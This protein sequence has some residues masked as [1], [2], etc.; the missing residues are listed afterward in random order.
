MKIDEMIET[1][2]FLLYLYNKYAHKI[3]K[4]ISH[5]DLKLLLII[6]YNDKDLKEIIKE[7]KE[8]KKQFLN[9]IKEGDLQKAYRIFKNIEKKF[10]EFENKSIERIENLVKIRA[11]DIARSK[12]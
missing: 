9:A 3:Y 1:S 8:G 5:A 10:V 12:N 7:L 6:S 2:W 4:K 11:L